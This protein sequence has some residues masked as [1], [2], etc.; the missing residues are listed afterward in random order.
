MLN[1]R[2]GA[3][4]FQIKYKFNYRSLTTTADNDNRCNAP[5]IGKYDS[6]DN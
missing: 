4:T 5:I 6:I 3:V 1:K 2:N